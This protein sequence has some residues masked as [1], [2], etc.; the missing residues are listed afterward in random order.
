LPDADGSP[1][2]P[3]TGRS[4]FRPF[5]LSRD[6][7]LLAL[8]TLLFGASF[9]FYQYV[10]PLFIASLGAGPDQV[11]LALAIG[12]S[13]SIVSILV[14]GLFVERYSYRWQMIVS[15][16]MSALATALF[17]VAWSWE[18]VA[19]ALLISTISLF[20]IPAFNAYIIAARDG[21]ETTDA[22]TTVFVGFTAGQTVTP[23]L[24]GW[25]IA[26]SGMPAM[27]LASLA[28][29]VASTAAVVLVRERPAA[30]PA[31]VGAGG[32][33]RRGVDL[34]EP[35]RAYGAAL[36][37]GPF[38]GLLVLL[39]VLYTATFTGVS[40]VPNF[41]HD[42]L[43]VDPS[44]IGV[45]GTGAAVVGIV[46]SL[47]LARVARR[48]GFYRTLALAQLM[49]SG[50]IGLILLAPGLGSDGVLV[51]GLGFAARG[52]IQAQQTLA[53]A[54]V[55]GVVRGAGLGPAFALQSTVF[56]VAMAVG[57]ALAGPLYAADPALPLWVAL[58]VGI[59]ISLWLG[60]RGQSL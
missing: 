53:R 35:F 36:T 20:G 48:L 52:A 32:K 2:A 17:V 43:G 37:N 21:Q 56:N 18:I 28:C 24:G 6:N 59:P 60:V 8:S 26:T 7:T 55:A 40:L 29:M 5:G 10:L 45:F 49:V 14:G 44:A 57:P 22:L 47:G 11:G 3:T 23:T 42:R 27:F 30:V 4:S 39:V 9:G 41:L 25:I 33:P 50:G 16:A 54:M 51:G 46:G 58:A 19:I 31:L 34:G 13:G 12:N 1:V 38:R 15:W